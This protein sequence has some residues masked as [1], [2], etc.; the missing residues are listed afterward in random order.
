MMGIVMVGHEGGVSHTH[1]LFPL[2]HIILEYIIPTCREKQI[3]KES[4]VSKSIMHTGHCHDGPHEGGVAFNH[5][6]LFLC[7]ILLGY[8]K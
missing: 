5:V 4:L 2:C 7:H 3:C 8:T 6:H 1:L